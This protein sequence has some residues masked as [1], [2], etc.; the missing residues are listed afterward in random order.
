VAVN[1]QHTQSLQHLESMLNDL[2]PGT[3]VTITYVSDGSQRS[4]SAKL[5]SLGS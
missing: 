1:G 5:G 4:G 2:N 3:K